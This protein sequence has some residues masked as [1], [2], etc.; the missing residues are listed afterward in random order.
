[1]Y[2]SVPWYISEDDIALSKIL[3]KV[4]RKVFNDTSRKEYNLGANENFSRNQIVTEMSAA[5]GISMALRDSLFVFDDHVTYISG[6]TVREMFNAD[7]VY[8]YDIPLEDPYRDDYV[9][10]TGMV[11]SKR[12]RAT[13][14]FKW[15]F[16]EAGKQK[17]LTYFDS[18][19]RNVWH[20]IEWKVESTNRFIKDETDG[21]QY[22]EL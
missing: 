8:F 22:E 5:L 7:T 11:V 2:P 10:C 14:I 3:A 17:Q 19:A 6:K 16:T 18:L 9:Y 13:M 21:N 20:D 15:F 12:G 4:D 1:M